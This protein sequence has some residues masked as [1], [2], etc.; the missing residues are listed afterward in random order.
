MQNTSLANRA[1]RGGRGCRV[2]NPTLLLVHPRS[3]VL[4]A[5]EVKLATAKGATS[6]LVPLCAWGGGDRRFL[7]VLSMGTEAATEEAPTAVAASN[8]TYIDCESVDIA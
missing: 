3:P 6:Q 1:G 7:R 8:D 5:R 4:Q 2:A